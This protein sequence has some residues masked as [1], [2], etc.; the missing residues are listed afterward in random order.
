M[1]VIQVGD[2]SL[3]A[4]R[5]QR[6]PDAAAAGDK[7][8]SVRDRHRRSWMRGSR[9]PRPPPREIPKSLSDRLPQRLVNCFPLVEPARPGSQTRQICPP[10][11]RSESCRP[12]KKPRWILS[13]DGRG[14]VDRSPPVAISQSVDRSFPP[15]SPGDALAVGREC[16][17]TGPIVGRVKASDYLAASRVQNRQGGFCPVIT[18]LVADCQEPAIGRKR[19]PVCGGTGTRRLQRRM[20]WR[21]DPELA[22]FPAGGSVPNR[23]V[24]IEPQTTRVCPSEEKACPQTPCSI[25]ASLCR[26]SPVTGFLRQSILLSSTVDSV[27]R[28]G[29]RAMELPS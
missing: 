21:G 26:T 1:L 8:S 14:N 24:V 12:A 25:L 13:P 11:R 15:A 29:D 23:Y 20:R 9:R 22:P 16:H 6:R 2:Q 19:C 28:S 7:G 17:L 27:F 5:P 18:D 10:S 4:F 3:R